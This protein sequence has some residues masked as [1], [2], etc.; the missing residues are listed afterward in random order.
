[1]VSQRMDRP[2]SLVT[3]KQIKGLDYLRR[4]LRK[5]G[6]EYRSAFDKEL[7]G[8]VAPIVRDAKLRYRKVYPRRR[9]GKGSQRGLRGSASGGNPR[10]ILGGNRYRWVLGQEWGSNKY[11]QFPPPATGGT[12][13]WPSVVEGAGDATDNILKAVDRANARAFPGV[14]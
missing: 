9:G 1:M 7:K 4:D 10:V 8:A 2:E 11:P 14:R 3:I 6:K 12:F 13:F 5:L